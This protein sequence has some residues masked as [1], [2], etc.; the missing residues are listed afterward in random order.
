MSGKT[1]VVTGATS[2]IGRAT[3]IAL[4]KM[5]AKVLITARDPGRGL[6]AAQAI[7]KEG[8]KSP[9]SREASP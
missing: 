2:G 4:S 9:Y 3:A 6:A 8:G 7:A 1:V 5:G